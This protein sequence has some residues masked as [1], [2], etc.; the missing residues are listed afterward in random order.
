MTIVKNV[1]IKLVKYTIDA[2]PNRKKKKEHRQAHICQG[3]GFLLLPIN[4]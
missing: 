1:Y 3:Y 2:N 4:H